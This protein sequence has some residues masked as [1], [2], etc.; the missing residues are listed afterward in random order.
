MKKPSA[1]L[2]ILFLISFD[3]RATDPR[4]AK[5]YAHFL[6]NREH[7]EN[8]R[9]RS[10]YDFMMYAMLGIIAGAASY[11]AVNPTKNPVYYFKSPVFIIEYGCP[12]YK[13]EIDRHWKKRSENFISGQINLNLL[14]LGTAKRRSDFGLYASYSFQNLAHELIVKDTIYI[15]PSYVTGVESNVY[16]SLFTELEDDQVLV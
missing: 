5:A 16:P 13:N 14:L 6:A 7:N 4:N 8:L 3:L 11:N 15:S 9:N 1:F 2:I 12:F 10:D